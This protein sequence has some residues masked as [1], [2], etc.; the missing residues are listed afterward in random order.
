MFA[1]ALGCNPAGIMIGLG[2]GLVIAIN[3]LGG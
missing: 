1:A 2:T 3:A